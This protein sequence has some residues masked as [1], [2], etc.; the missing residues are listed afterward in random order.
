[1]SVRWEILCDCVGE[2]RIL[3]GRFRDLAAH[4]GPPVNLDEA[5]KNLSLRRLVVV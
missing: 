2:Q 5:A 1:M 4:V 3:V